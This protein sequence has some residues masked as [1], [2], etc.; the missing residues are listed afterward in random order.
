M[1]RGNQI[2]PFRIKPDVLARLDK[3]LT[4]L[5]AAQPSNPWNRTDFIINAI[6][7]ALLEWETRD[8]PKPPKKRKK[9]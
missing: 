8:E 7:K 5:N 2:I 1:A 4:E 3:A 6:R 9:L